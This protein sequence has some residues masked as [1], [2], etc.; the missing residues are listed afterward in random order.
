M[1]KLTIICSMGEKEFMFN[2]TPDDKVSDLIEAVRTHFGYSSLG[3]YGLC[4]Y[5]D[6]NGDFDPNISIKEAGIRDGQTLAFCD[7][8]GAV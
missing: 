3:R 8:G 2:M 6:S 1:I 4:T 5:P 7:W